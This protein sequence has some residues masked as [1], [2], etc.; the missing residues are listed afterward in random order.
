MVGDAKTGI[1][2]TAMNRQNAPDRRMSIMN[3]GDSAIL[4][5]LATNR[6]TGLIYLCIF[7]LLIM[8]DYAVFV[9]DPELI[10]GLEKAKITLLKH[11]IV[12]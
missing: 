12:M 1:Q 9:D 10:E 3:E 6:R 11:L 4:S 7:D 2:R 5:V 8:S